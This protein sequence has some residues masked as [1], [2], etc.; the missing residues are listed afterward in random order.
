MRLAVRDTD[1]L[2]PRAVLIR[3]SGLRKTYLQALLAGLDG[4][5]IAG[6]TTTNDNEVLLLGLGGI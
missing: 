5:N 4:G 2:P 6:D 3:M 1:F